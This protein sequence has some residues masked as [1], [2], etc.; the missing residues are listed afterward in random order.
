MTQPSGHLAGDK[1]EPTNQAPKHS[2][3]PWAFGTAMGMD[4][5]YHSGNPHCRV[6]KIYG[7]CQTAKFIVTACNSHTALVERVAKLEGALQTLKDE[8]EDFAGYLET[9]HS[10][11]VPVKYSDAWEVA[12]V[13]LEGK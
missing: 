3:L 5:V 11:M 1:P 6:A 2:P 10:L 7:D 8:S 13:A 9:Q 4:F 12:R